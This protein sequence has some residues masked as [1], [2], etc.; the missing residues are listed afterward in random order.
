MPGAGKT[1]PQRPPPCYLWPPMIRPLALQSTR[2]LCRWPA[3]ALAI[4]LAMACQRASDGPVEQRKAAADPAVDQRTRSAAVLVRFDNGRSAAI[5]DSALLDLALGGAVAPPL[6]L[7]PS[8][9]RLQVAAVFADIDRRDTQLLTTLTGQTHPGAAIPALDTCMRQPEAA[10]TTG[11]STPTALHDWAQL[12]DVG[13]LELRVGRQRLPL[14][15]QL[16]PAVVESA[17]GVRYDFA[18]DRARGLLSASPMHLVATGGDG[19]GAFEA[20]VAVPRPV[21]VTHV[22]PVAVRQGVA[23]GVPQNEDLRLRWGSVDGT[24]DLEVRV[25]SE[26]PGAVGWVRCRLRDDG[27]FAVPASLTADL[28]ARGPRRPWLVVLVRGRTAA[29]QGFA[30]EPLRLE[31][32]DSVHVY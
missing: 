30:G 8:E 2:A 14:R 23:Q 9:D 3:A 26:E 21:R 11:L 12:L 27:E 25:G 16:L 24:A 5:Q 18:Q 13:N 6:T 15:V 10:R 32:A 4:L 1:M 31:L 28:P 20:A 17:R 19:V 29:I 7:T 22:G